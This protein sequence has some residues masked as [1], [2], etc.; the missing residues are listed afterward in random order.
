MTDLAFE[1]G[2]VLLGE[3]V[4]LRPFEERDFDAA[5]G[6]SMIPRHD[7]SRGRT[8]PSPAKR[9]VA[10]IEPVD[11]PPI[12]SISLSRFATTIGWSAR[13]CS[14]ISTRTT[15]AAGS[16]IRGGTIG[17]RP[18][19]RHRSHTTHCRSRLRRRYPPGEPGGVRLQPA[20]P[21]GVWE[22]WPSPSRRS[23]RRAVLGGRIPRRG[24]DGQIGHQQGVARRA[25]QLTAR[26]WVAATRRSS[27]RRPGRVR[28]GAVGVEAG[29]EGCRRR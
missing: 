2:T 26:V 17:L 6:C 4:R 24:P 14:V 11:R 25:W 9:P 7:D 3:R 21:A 8:P 5:W 18:R 28:Y 1:P 27:A 29:A 23:T 10:G 16:A 20:R 15:T 13:R 22:G 19:L 12:G